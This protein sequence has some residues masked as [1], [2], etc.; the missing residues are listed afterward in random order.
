[1]KFSRRLDKL[2]PYLFAE[3]DRLKSEKQAEGFDVIS[4][5]V[6]DPD[7]PTSPLVVEAMKKAVQK[8]KHHRYPPYEGTMEFRKAVSDY[9]F[10]RYQVKLAPES[11]IIALIG[12]KEGIAHLSMSVLDQ[13]DVLLVPDPGYP[14]YK[15]GGLFAGAEIYPMPLLKQNDFLPDFTKIPD[16]VAKKAALMFLN[17]PNN[18]TAAGATMEFYSEAVEFAKKYDLI[19]ASDNAYGDIYFDD[20]VPPSI[21][22]IPGAIDVTVEFFSLS[23]MYNMTGWRIGAVLGNKK[24][25]NALATFKKNIDSGT[26][27]AI[28]EAGA[29]ALRDGDEFIDLMR[30]TY[31]RRR[32]RMIDALKS[33]GIKVDVP[34]CSFYIW[35][36]TPNNLKS[37]NFTKHLLDKTGVLVSPGI[38][39][40]EYG[41]GYFRISLTL[42]D[43]MLDEAVR[44]I[45]AHD[46]SR[47]QS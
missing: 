7:V 28:Q 24:V 43:K 21:L 14:V 4:L 33:I 25:I 47:V 23:K 16:R 34:R 10:R 17:Y 44:R 41:E 18:P 26:F 37:M 5:G 6:G 13:Q 12:T 9:Y 46:F 36:P 38:G 42:P 19:I 29:T 39:F 22:K 15:T 30:S 45:K 11:E 20:Y 1:M 3:L 2:P 40:G 35:A 27:T 32:D 8:P 31:R